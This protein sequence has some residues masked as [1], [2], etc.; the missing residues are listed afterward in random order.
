[1]LNSNL[2]GALFSTLFITGLGYWLRKSGKVKPETAKQLTTILLS[3]VLPA[4]SFN[5][6]MTDFKKEE[7][8]QGIW[9]L[10]FSFFFYVSMIF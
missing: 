8:I 7:F 6:F 3:V 2:W 5:A 4:L 9:V 10:V 1:M